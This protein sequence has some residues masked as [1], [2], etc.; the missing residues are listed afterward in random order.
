LLESDFELARKM[1]RGIRVKRRSKLLKFE[2][3]KI[4]VETWK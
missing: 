3:Q 4:D 1:L 2:K